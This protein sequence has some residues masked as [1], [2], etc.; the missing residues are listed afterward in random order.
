V[1]NH[2][3]YKAQVLAASRLVETLITEISL[4]RDRSEVFD[5]ERRAMEAISSLHSPDRERLEERVSA[6]V[7]KRRK[8]LAR[9]CW[10]AAEPARIP[11]DYPP[12]FTSQAARCQHT[13]APN[14][15]RRTPEAKRTNVS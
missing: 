9:F 14:A 11:R 4:T 5:F 6:S 8:D 1:T 2:S 10:S 13:G 15:N 12:H 3:T 7:F